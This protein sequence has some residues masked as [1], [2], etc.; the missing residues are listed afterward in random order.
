MI[1]QMELHMMNCQKNYNLKSFFEEN[2][3][4]NNSNNSKIINNELIK[5]I[6]KNA[7]KNKIELLDEGDFYVLYEITKVEKNF[8]FK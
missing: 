5:K 2:F 8:T 4:S 3:Q 1:F 7:E 6:F